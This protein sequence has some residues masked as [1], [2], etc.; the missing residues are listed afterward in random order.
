MKF[1]LDRDQ[2]FADAEQAHD[3][4]DEAHAL[5]QFIDAHGQPHAAGHRIDADAASAKPIASETSVLIGGAPPMP[6]K[7]AKARKYTAKYSGGP[8]ASATCATQEAER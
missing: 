8:K 5:D 7:L 1:L 4:D 2:Q 3:R 6:T